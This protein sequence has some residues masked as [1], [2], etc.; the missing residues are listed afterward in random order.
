MMLLDFA[1]LTQFIMNATSE[2][3]SFWHM[4]APPV[5]ISTNGHLIDW[6]FYYT[7]W[8]N[9][10]F[11]TLVCIGLFG[12][13]YLYSAKRHPVAYYTYGNKKIHITI[14]TVIGLAVFLA[15]D[16]NITR[17]SNNDYINVFANFPDEDDE[18]VLR[19]QVLAQQWA[20]NFRYAGADGVFNT[21]DDVITLNDLRLPVDRK[22]VFQIVSKDVIHSFFLPNARLKVDA[23]PGRLT[24]MWVELTEPGNY[25]IVC[26]E[27][28]GT[29]H[30]RMQAYLTVYSEEDFDEWMS[31]AERNAVKENELDNADLYWGWKWELN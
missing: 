28:C 12:F 5:D 2:S 27:M 29:F 11:F 25:D 24:R 17:I 14:A 19:V 15:V 26:A 9:I 1:P 3:T 21:E 10:F 16:M 4:F 6:L 30:Y 22:V 7:T 8:M 18:D 20:W 13:S 23:I 31:E